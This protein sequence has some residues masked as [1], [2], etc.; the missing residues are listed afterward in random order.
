MRREF[1]LAVHWGQRAFEQAPTAVVT[2]RWLA[3][4]LG[5]AKKHEEA[6]ALMKKLR[7]SAPTVSLAIERRKPFLHECM[8]EL[9][10]DGLRIAGLPK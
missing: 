6:V 5:Q 4:S 2:M 1:D 8:S 10:V 9:Y 3:A 7:A